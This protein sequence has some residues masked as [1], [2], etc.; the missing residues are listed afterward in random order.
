[1]KKNNHKILIK[2][3]KKVLIVLYLEFTFQHNNQSDLKDIFPQKK[4]SYQ[5]ENIRNI[6]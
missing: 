2:H 5:K 1:M 6:Q 4:S 3:L